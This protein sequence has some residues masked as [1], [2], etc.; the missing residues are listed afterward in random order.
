MANLAMN[1][2]VIFRIVVGIFVSFALASALC[3]Q[4][5]RQLQVDLGPDQKIKILAS[6]VTYGEVLRV[7]EKKLG[8]QIEIPASADKLKISY[9]RIESAQPAI[10]LAKLLEGSRLGYALQTAGNKSQTVKVVVT[11][12]TSGEASENN[13]TVSNSATPANAEAETSLPLRRPTPA[14]TRTKRDAAT[15][16]TDTEQSDVLPTVPLAEAINAMGVPIGV[17]PSDVGKTTTLPITDA[18]KLMGVPPGMSPGDV[19][20]TT[21][22]PLPTG[23]GM[24]P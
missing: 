23:P 17:S 14:M 8:W 12:A 15:A 22:L 2:F 1:R 6:D 5:P 21:T 11:P 4:T 19:G 13:E 9:L 24:H 16:G 10:V 20:K 18:A 3:A 7:L